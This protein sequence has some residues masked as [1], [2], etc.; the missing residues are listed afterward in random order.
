M[1][2]AEEK[3]LT[4]GT[5]VLREEANQW[6][7]NAKLRLGGG[8]VVI[9]WEGF[10]REFFTK[11]FPADVK[12]KKVVEFMKLEHGNMSMAEYAA[13]FNSLCV[14]S[15]H[16]NTLEAENDK[17]VKFESDGKAKSSYFK[18][19]RGK[20]QGRVKPYEQEKDVCYNYG[21]EGHRSKECKATTPTCYNCGEEGYK[22]P[23]CKK[24]KKIIGKVFALN[25]EEADQVDNLIRET[26]A[27][28]LVTT[29]LVYRNSLVTV[30]GKHFGMD[31]VCIRLSDVSDLPPE[32]EVEFS[33]DLVPGTSPISMA[34]Y[35]MSA[36]ELNE[37]KKQLE[38]LLE[39]RFIRPSVSLWGAPVLLVK[40]KEGIMRLCIDYRQ[41]NKVTIKN[42][43]PLPSIDDLMDQLVGAHLFSKIDLRSGYHQIRVKIEDIPKTAFRTRYDHYEYT[44]MPFGVTN[45]LGVFMEYMNKIFHSLLDKFVIVFIDDI[46]IYSKSEEEHKGHLGI[47]LQVL[48]EKELYAKLSKYKFWLK[49]VIFLGHVISSGGIAVDPA[50]VEAVL[51]WGT[52]ESLSSTLVAYLLHVVFIV[53]SNLLGWL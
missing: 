22:S 51:Q 46:L 5:Y 18:A 12:N 30:F 20:S 25:G 52:P 33:I 21:K 45:A 41:L 17:C 43:Y 26:S 27:S 50:K 16:Y 47:V 10:K 44:V 13:K 2:C 34:L 37:L 32:R 38:E 6:W 15:P 39:K 42:K 11:Y 31:L 24:S 28:G 3:K 1:E 35:R 48:K 23:A 49:E 7:K 4:L 9:T 53:L 14:F 29:Q 40:K 19:I 8:R 36:S